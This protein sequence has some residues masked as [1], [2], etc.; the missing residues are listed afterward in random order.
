MD[1]SAYQPILDPRQIDPALKIVILKD[2]E[3]YLTDPDLIING[4]IL[5]DAGKTIATYIWPDPDVSP[6][7]NIDVAATAIAKAGLPLTAAFLDIEQYTDSLT[8]AIMKPANI[9]EHARQTYLL[10]KQ[11]FGQV[12]I[13]TN[14]NFTMSWAPPMSTWL[15][16]LKV[17]LWVAEYKLEPSTHT[18]LGWSD[19]LK[20]WLPTYSPDLPLECTLAQLVGHQF[21]GDRFCLP[22]IYANAQLVRSPLDV[23]MFDPAFFT[24]KLSQ[25]PAPTVVPNPL[26]MWRCTI[27]LLNVR[28]GPSTN[29]SIWGT[30][31]LGTAKMATEVVNGWVHFA[32]NT[33]ASAAYMTRV[34]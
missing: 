13:Y 17:P 21:S 28:T 6:Q 4:K 32:D 26:Q 10:A 11:A 12:G 24:G 8:K 29:Y 18:L 27:P 22:G 9:S 19:L 2:S 30:L 20:I 25:A 33:W 23:N 14:R 15:S 16:E 7:A 5:A 1:I 34:A 3:G 31:K